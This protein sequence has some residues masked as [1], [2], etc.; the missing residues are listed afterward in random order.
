M[1]IHILGTMTRNSLDTNHH[2]ILL[3]NKVV[4]TLELI[5]MVTS[6]RRGQTTVATEDQVNMAPHLHMGTLDNMAITNGNIMTTANQTMR[7][8]LHPKKTI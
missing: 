3:S 7:V 4:H 2:H 1:V 5:L 6:T 8:T